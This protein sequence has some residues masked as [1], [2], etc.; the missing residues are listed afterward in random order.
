MADVD[1][2]IVGGGMVGLSL[3]LAL[4]KGKA[5]REL[6]IV[7]V[8]GTPADIDEG[9]PLWYRV[10]AITRGSERFLKKIKGW[11][12]QAVRSPYDKMQVWDATGSG[13]IAFDAAELAE[14]NLGHI[15][16]NQHIREALISECQ[17]HDNIRL[18][19]PAKAV[20]LT[21]HEDGTASMTL[22]N[23]EQIKAR[24]LV[25]ADGGN[26]WLRAHKNLYTDTASYEQ[27]AVIC[28]INTESS[29]AYTARQRFLPTGPLALL[30]LSDVHQC[31]IVWS[32]TPEEASR[33]KPLSDDEF[34]S[35][36]T[37]ASGACLGNLKVDSPRF[38]IPLIRRHV[39]RYLDD[40][41][42]LIGDAAHTIHPLAGQG[43]NLGLMDA[44]TL[45]EVIDGA[46][47]KGHELTNLNALRPYER[48][49]RSENQMMMDA[50]SFFRHLFDGDQGFKVWLR[51]NGLSMVDKLPWVKEKIMHQAMGLEGD[52]PA[53][54]RVVRPAE[55]DI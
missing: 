27:A 21:E 37:E 38:V 47:L 48:W 14:P 53:L 6:S 40:G 10:S 46:L 12:E 15:I 2:L 11:P 17:R 45:A 51:N 32:T 43:A 7:I 41:L 26:S 24:L 28:Q 31:S 35:E 49:R 20:A 44:A 3:A 16:A 13:S 55:K 22:D 39:E 18:I 8:D 54:A 29:H 9:H 34:S 1:L 36:L 23:D 42:V 52:L 4:Q 50:M 19:A 33:L 25:A 5:S 30:P